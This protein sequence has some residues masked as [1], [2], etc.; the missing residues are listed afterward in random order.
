MQMIM[1]G[2]GSGTISVC[3]HP[4]ATAALSLP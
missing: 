4:V 2:R 1:E 3:C